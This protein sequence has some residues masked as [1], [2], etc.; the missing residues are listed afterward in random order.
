DLHA[1]VK[2]ADDVETFLDDR[3][4]E[5][6]LRKDRGVGMEVDGRAAASR[7]PK[8]LQRA[9]RFALLEPQFP[10]RAIASHRGDQLLGERID[11]ARA[12]AVEAAGGFVVAGL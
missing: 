6:D 8:L 5:L 4:I 12:D 10:L 9:D 3:G 7:G 1:L 11:D 2:I